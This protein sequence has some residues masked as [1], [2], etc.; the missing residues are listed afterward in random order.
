MTP[1]AVRSAAAL[2]VPLAASVMARAVV[3]AEVFS[4][5]PP[6]K[7]SAPDAAPRFASEETDNVP[8]LMVVPPV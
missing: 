8:A 7:I 2:K 6:L 3:K 5:V 4:S 1:L